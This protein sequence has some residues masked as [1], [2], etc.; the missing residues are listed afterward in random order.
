M[1][2]LSQLRK[3]DSL[4]LFVAGHGHTTTRTFCDGESV[5][6]GFIIPVDGDLPGRSPTRWLRLDSW[7]SDLARLEVKH[8]LIIL[9]SCFSGIALE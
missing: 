2:D 3:D 6:T 7:L 4:I 5:K 1:D 8:T 9:D